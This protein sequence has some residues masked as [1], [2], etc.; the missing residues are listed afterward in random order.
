MDRGVEQP[1]APTL[2]GFAI[3]RILLDVWHHPRI[4]DRLAI[5]LGI[6]PTIQVEIRAFQ[7]Q[8]REFGHPLERLETLGQQHRI[9]F[10]HWCHR[11]RSQHVAVV[12]NNRDD[13]FP[14]LMFVAGVP[15]AIPP[16][17]ATVLVPSPWS[18]VISSCFSTARC[19]TLA[20]NAC[21]S[22]PSSAH[23]ALDRPRARS[24]AGLFSRRYLSTSP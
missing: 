18:T 4:E 16:F 20:T 23:F 11:K 9:G 3:T 17:L 12:V 1:L 5:R 10:V 21:H 22:D 14:L 24:I 13:L 2:G 6:E 15:D 19:R 8:A 7:P